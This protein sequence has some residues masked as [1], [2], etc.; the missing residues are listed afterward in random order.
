MVCQGG[1]TPDR[2]PVLCDAFCCADD[3]IMGFALEAD[4]HRVMDVLPKR[5]HRFGLTIHPEKTV[6]LA[7]QRPPSRAPSA[8]RDGTFNF[9][10][11]THYWARTRRGYWV[12]K[13]KTVGKRLRRFMKGIG[14]WCRE[15][16]HVPL[17][18]AV[19]GLVRE[20]ARPLPILWY[21]WQLQ[22]ARID[23]RIIPSEH[24]QYWL[25]RRSHK[26]HLNWQ[27]FEG[28]V[29]PE[30]AAPTTQDHS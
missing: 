19:S 4:A 17:E 7:F 18:R 22:D 14:T 16:R 12:I 6:L 15:H 2:G 3:F 25:S 21:P 26:G 28:A 11:F 29:R 24:W 20:T 30:T 9:L 5:F 1:S 13:R 27:K 10:G 8:R 23:D